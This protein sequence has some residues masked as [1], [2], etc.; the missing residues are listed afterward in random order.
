MVGSTPTGA[1]FLLS[2]H[3]SYKNPTKT[4]NWPQ[5]G[6]TSIACLARYA[7]GAVRDFDHDHD[8]SMQITG[9]T[10]QTS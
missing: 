4:P 10:V 2:M 5:N 6:F 3:V 7:L 9:H 1:I 8:L